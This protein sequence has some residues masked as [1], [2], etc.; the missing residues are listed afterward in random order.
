MNQNVKVG[1]KVKCQG[2]TRTIKEIISAF[3]YG[4]EDGWYIEFIA[5][6]TGRYCYWKQGCDGGELLKQDQ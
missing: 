6:E 3:N 4:E 2:I 1:D 5:K